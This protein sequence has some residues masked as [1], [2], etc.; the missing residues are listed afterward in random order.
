MSAIKGVVVVI[1]LA[2]TVVWSR[3]LTFHNFK[4][5][6]VQVENEE[7]LK[8]LKALESVGHEYD[9]FTYWK[10]PIIGSNADLVVPPNMINEFNALASKL[11]LNYSLKIADIQ[12]LVM[13]LSIV[14][15]LGTLYQ[16]FLLSLQ[17]N[18]RRN[19]STTA[20]HIFWMG[21]LSHIGGNKRLARWVVRIIS[22]YFVISS[23]WLFL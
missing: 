19:T 21:K 14:T 8:A 20:T 6:N 7:Q 5:F 2:T 13:F 4:V 16:W 17:V 18:R 12:R 15:S 9:G 22:R 3:Q 1:L 10:E 23:C 11:K